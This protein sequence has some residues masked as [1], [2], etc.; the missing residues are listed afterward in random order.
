MTQDTTVPSPFLIGSAELPTEEADAVMD[1]AVVTEADVA[2]LE[3]TGT[4][5]VACMQ[6]MFTNDVEQPGE[7]GFA[8]GA[9]LTPK[10][11]IITDAWLTRDGGRVSLAVP[12]LGL[13]PLTEVLTRSLPPRLARVAD[14]TEEMGVLRLAGPLAHGVAERAGIAIPP[15]GRAT[16][17]IAGDVACTVAHPPAD[18][19]FA[20][21]IVTARS[22]LVAVREQI[23]A[24]GALATGP[25]ATELA[26]ILSGW[27]RLGA[28]INAKTL[29]QEVRLDAI[30]GVSYTKGCY[31]GQ[32][33]VSR[34]H[35]RGHP[36]RH[37]I[38]LVWD[39]D[40]EPVGGAFEQGDRLR[41][42]V[43]SIAWLA[44]VDRF[45]GL[46]VVRREVDLESAVI[47]GGM[48]AR[49]VNLPFLFDA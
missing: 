28:E 45:I 34:V 6:G 47:A 5:T 20:L 44:A 49:V 4:G 13:D 19:P 9:V 21:Q 7:G 46:A 15:E 27:P 26:R 37:L 25:H 36:N 18:M 39:D 22:D 23:V 3:V 30:N 1:G 14:R 10:G 16:A 35:F 12:H 24:A 43:T 29:P 32:E 11:M 38:G 48:P 40:A 31:T 17:A 8:Y 42:R 2:V 41:G 33:T